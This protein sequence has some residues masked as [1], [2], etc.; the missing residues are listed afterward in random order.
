MEKNVFYG[1]SQKIK[2][3]PRWKPH[4]ETPEE[5]T[6]EA[7]LI[8][9]TASTEFLT[10]YGTKGLLEAFLHLPCADNRRGKIA[11]YIHAL[12]LDLI[13]SRRQPDPPDNQLELF[14]E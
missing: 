6:A 14:K 5:W 3:N 2:K 4:W 10:R 1:L 7:L 8:A 11:P 12:N 9:Q 13:I